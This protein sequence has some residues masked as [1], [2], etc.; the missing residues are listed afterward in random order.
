MTSLRSHI[1][2][3]LECGATEE[4]I[5]RD[6]YQLVPYFGTALVQRAVQIAIREFGRRAAERLI[7]DR[8]KE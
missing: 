5:L 3:A 2:A 8:D 4:E 7:P 6:L 1:N